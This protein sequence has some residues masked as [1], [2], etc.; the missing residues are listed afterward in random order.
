M[1]KEQTDP[2]TE[3]TAISGACEGRILQMDKTLFC[4]QM[5]WAKHA[6][7]TMP[8]SLNP[9]IKLLRVS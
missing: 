9:W 1:T 6:N 2:E 8:I 5:A 3:L 4:C 7:A